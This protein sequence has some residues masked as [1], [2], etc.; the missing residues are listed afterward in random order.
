M[1]TCATCGRPVESARYGEMCSRCRADRQQYKDHWFVR[2]LEFK[3]PSLPARPKR[4]P[5]PGQQELFVDQ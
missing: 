3:K 2:S 4:K 5:F 1:Q